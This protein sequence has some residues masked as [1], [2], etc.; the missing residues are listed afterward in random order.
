MFF[1]PSQKSPQSRRVPASPETSGR[2]DTVPVVH[3]VGAGPGDPELLTRKAWRLLQQAE[4]IV[5]DRLVSPAVLEL[6][7]P[8]AR[9]IDVGKRPGGGGYRQEEINALLCHLAG[10]RR[11]VVRLKGGDP[12]VFGR[13]GEELAA[14]RARGFAAEVV[15]GITAATA[16]A[17]DAG[18]PLTHRG[19]ATAVTLVTGH[20]E[21]GDPD[22]DWARLASPQHTIALYMAVRRA[23]E[24]AARLMAE[25]LD[26]DTPVAVVERASS[27]EQRC[28]HGTLGGL[29]ALVRE[30]RVRA[31]A[32]I[33]IGAVADQAEAAA[34]AAPWAALAETRS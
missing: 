18:I 9:R 30:Q 23:P 27:P 2:G 6:A 13:G 34:M 8:A 21:S 33:I 19:T 3:I 24:V 1:D 5:H 15:P 7:H 20:G 16:A 17:A 11:R 10:Q 29:A 26:A 14:L 31:P 25:G 32:L 22:L 4:V 28:L 12:F